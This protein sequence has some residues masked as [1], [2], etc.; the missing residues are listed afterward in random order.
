MPSCTLRPPRQLYALMTKDRFTLS[1]NNS[2]QLAHPAP[3]SSSS[4]AKPHAPLSASATAL[5]TA[6]IAPSAT[7]VSTIKLSSGG[8]ATITSSNVAPSASPATSATNGTGRGST[9]SLH[10]AGQFPKCPS[11]GNTV[12]SAISPGASRHAASTEAR[13]LATSLSSRITAQHPPPTTLPIGGMVAARS[14]T[15]GASASA[16]R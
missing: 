4:S 6:S 12:G 11:P 3:S 7:I 16:H 1:S 15:F 9:S 14:P 2:T 10:I 8:I 5:N 13:S